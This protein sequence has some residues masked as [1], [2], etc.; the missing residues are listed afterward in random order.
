MAGEASPEIHVVELAP[1]VFVAVPAPEAQ[2]VDPAARPH[3]SRVRH[4]ALAL[5]PIA[6][7]AAAWWMLQAA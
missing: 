4:A 2:A 6:T 5:V 7:V 3:R 1:G